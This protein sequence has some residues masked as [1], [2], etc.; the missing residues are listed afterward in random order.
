[1]SGIGQIGWTFLALALWGVLLWFV[2]VLADHLS[3]DSRP[4]DFL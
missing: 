3:G 4:E 1:M 2:F